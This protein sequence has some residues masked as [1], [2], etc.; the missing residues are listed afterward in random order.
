MNDE[1]RTQPKDPA[2]LLPYSKRLIP[3]DDG[4][5]QLPKQH[6]PSDPRLFGVS[7]N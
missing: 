7:Y 5:E 6:Q 1:E 4:A 2:K 3:K